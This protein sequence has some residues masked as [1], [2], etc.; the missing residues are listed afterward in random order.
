MKTVLIVEDDKTLGALMQTKLESRGYQVTHLTNYESA[1][2][3]LKLNTFDLVILDLLLDNQTSLSLIEP[4]IKKE[5]NTK[6]LVLT[7]FASIATAVEAVKRGAHNYLPKP[8]TISEIL[9]AMDEQEEP[10]H[11]IEKDN[12]VSDVLSPKRL[13]WEHIQRVLHKNDGNISATARELKMH[14]RTLQR[15]LQKNPVRN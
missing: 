8:A 10:S 13:E 2:E 3:Y 14:R 5:P 7:G 4:I 9:V 6:I 12:N 11:A 1:F 15:K